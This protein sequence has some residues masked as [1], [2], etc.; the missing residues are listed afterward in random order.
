MWNLLTFLRLSFFPK[1]KNKY[2]S[3][4][5]SKFVLSLVYL[6]FLGILAVDLVRE[7]FEWGKIPTDVANSKTLATF[8]SISFSRGWDEDLSRTWPWIVYIL[9]MEDRPV[10][11]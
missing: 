3:R 1:F 8:I 11:L 5:Y 10:L 4:V 6:F 9:S 7:M 2:F